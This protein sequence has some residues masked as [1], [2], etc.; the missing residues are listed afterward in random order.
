MNRFLIIFILSF[1]LQG[2]DLQLPNDIRWVAKSKEYK[3]LCEQVFSHAKY[4]CKIKAQFYNS[5]ANF[6]T[7]AVIM[8][9]DETVLDNSQYQ[10]E[11]FYNNETFN[12]NSWSSWV[13]REEAKL[14]PGAK[15]FINFIRS[16]D[17]SNIF[18]S[19]RMDERL[20]ATKS[21]LK[22][23]G[24]SNDNDIFLLRLNKEDTKDV[25]RIRAFFIFNFS[26]F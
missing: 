2:K 9:L 3:Q 24:V 7:P 6:K 23:L 16:L 12:I 13:L 18:I 5:N 14:I 25:R 10:I 20:S 26:W 19:N 17:I 22:K 11:L 4:I 8:D 15:D 21:N 1:F